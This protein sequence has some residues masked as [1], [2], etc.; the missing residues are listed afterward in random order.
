MLSSG[1]TELRPPMDD[2]VIDF[3][4]GDAEL[5]PA[6]SLP[7]DIYNRLAATDRRSLEHTFLERYGAVSREP[8]GPDETV[9]FLT[10]SLAIDAVARHLAKE[11]VRRIGVPEPAF[12]N[13][14]GLLR[15]AGLEPVPFQENDE[16]LLSAVDALDAVFL[17]LPNNPTGWSPSQR[18]LA[19]LPDLAKARG[20]RVVVDRI[21]RFHQDRQHSKLFLS[22]FEWIDVQETGK[23]WSTG[24][25][26]LAFVRTRSQRTLAALRV[27]SD[28]H[29]RAVP[30]LNLY[31][32]AEA[33]AL[34]GGDYR[35]RRAI[36]RNRC[37][38]EDELGAL[39]F[40]VVSRPL[41]VALVALPRTFPMGSTRLAKALQA[42][43]IEVIPGRALFWNSPQVGEQYIRVA[44]IRPPERFEV[45]AA[46]LAAAIRGCI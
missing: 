18:A 34:E 32:N 26:K 14:P 12:D 7:T 45:H 8:F 30:P 4:S 2:C 44:L 37:V 40:T 28:L 35:V 21:C 15:E 24:G 29:A 1:S 39:G 27:E 19:A 46:A 31:I 3:A 43:D 22:D 41:G 13:L 20:C 10:A 5:I 36:V 16:S 6:V 25:T 38:L 17:V 11:G 42:V 33:I 23:T 9:F